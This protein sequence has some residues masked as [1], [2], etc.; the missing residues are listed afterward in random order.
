[1]AD[2][3][4]AG[5]VGR[6]RMALPGRWRG[7]ANRVLG[8]KVLSFAGPRRSGRGRPAFCFEGPSEWAR[9]PKEPKGFPS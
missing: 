5:G 6:V 8:I 3:A 2:G 9:R 7:P 4:G 1:L